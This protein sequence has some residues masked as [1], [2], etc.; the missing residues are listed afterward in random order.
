M[1]IDFCLMSGIFLWIIIIGAETILKPYL[2]LNFKFQIKQKNEQ[3][4]KKYTDYIFY[5][6][7]CKIN[8]AFLTNVLTD[9]DWLLS[10]VRNF[11][12]NHY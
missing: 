9:N 2:H 5:L 4:I 3:S 11:D 7:D 12:V 1:M 6:T 10:E 8:I